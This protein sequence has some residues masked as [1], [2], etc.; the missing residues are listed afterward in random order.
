[1]I[2]DNY[3]RDVCREDN[4]CQNEIL[5][6][7]PIRNGNLRRKKEIAERELNV[8]RHEIVSLHEYQN[9]SSKARIRTDV[10]A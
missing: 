2:G 4:M 8:A 5:R 10:Y 6:C 9:V 1:M 3:S 7:N